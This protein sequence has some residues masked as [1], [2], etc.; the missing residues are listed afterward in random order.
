MAYYAFVPKDFE[1]HGVLRMKWGIRRYQP[2]PKGKRVKGGIEVGEAAKVKQRQKKTSVKKS[3]P[4]KVKEESKEEP[5][6]TI[7]NMTDEEIRSAVAR[8]KLEKEF[9]ELLASSTPKK[10]TKGR[11]LIEKIL[12]KGAEDIG[13]QLSSTVMGLFVNKVG[14]TLFK[15]LDHDLVNP[16][17]SQK[18]K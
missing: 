7:K 3:T 15:D 6:K 12:T 5:K 11:D 16:Y 10:S 13:G 14:K 18:A 8:L 1:H 2:Y 17:K 9:K 4:V